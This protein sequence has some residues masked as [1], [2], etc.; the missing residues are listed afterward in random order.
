[1]LTGS[2]EV[3]VVDDHPVVRDGVAAQL[4]HHRDIRIIGVATTGEEALSVCGRL[5]PAVVVLDVRMPDLAAPDIVAGIREVSP[6]TRILLFTAFPEHVSVAS[7]FTAG[8][9]GLVVKDA[10]LATLA[11]AIHD[12]VRIGRYRSAD[13]DATG[14]AAAETA[15]VSAREYDVVRLVAS[16]LTNI[17]IAEQLQL[18]SNTVKA[19][20]R[21]VMRKLD[22][23]NRAQ[24]IT[25]ARSHG[26]L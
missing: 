7:T 23:R 3:V 11:T 2:I 18:S 25:R 19:Y 13:D 21:T 5:R 9:A 4:S 10:S 17:E 8:A 16:G 22:A 14:S 15:L 24:L 12:V 26:L 20:L 1:M 6:V